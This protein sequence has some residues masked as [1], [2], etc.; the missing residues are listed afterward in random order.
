MY[1]KQRSKNF[2][3]LDLETFIDSIQKLAHPKKHKHESA[4]K[5]FKSVKEAIFEFESWLTIPKV[6]IEMGLA[7]LNESGIPVKNAWDI[8]L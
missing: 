5:M 4:G 7:L 3:V 6:S 8:V 1:D 2:D